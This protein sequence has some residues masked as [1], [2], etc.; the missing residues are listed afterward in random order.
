MLHDPLIRAWGW[1]I[2]L[3]LG[4]TVMAQLPLPPH[5][6]AVTGA[7][8]LVLAWAKARIILTRYLGLHAAPFWCRGFELALGFFCC[9]LLG[10]YLM[11]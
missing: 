2:G 8:I 1:L 4:S 5:L 9:L 10:L 7:A 3:S 6:A 11:A